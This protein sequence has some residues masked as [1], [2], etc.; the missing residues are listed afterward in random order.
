MCIFYADYANANNIILQM[1]DFIIW[2]MNL[3]RNKDK[4]VLFDRE[5]DGMIESYSQKL[6][7]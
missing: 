1:L 4:V 6:K 3:Y 5:N 7:N 2:I